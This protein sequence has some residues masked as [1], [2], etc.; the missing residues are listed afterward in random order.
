MVKPT[1][2]YLCTPIFRPLPGRQCDCSPRLSVQKADSSQGC[3]FICRAGRQAGSN[4]GG[5]RSS[6][7]VSATVLAASFTLPEGEGQGPPRTPIPPR[8]APAGEGWPHAA[9][10][11]QAAETCLR[12]VA[13]AAGRGGYPTQSRLARRSHHRRRCDGFTSTRQ[14]WRLMADPINQ[15]YPITGHTKSVDLWRRSAEYA[16]RCTQSRRP[17]SRPPRS[18]AIPLHVMWLCCLRQIKDSQ[19]L[20]CLTFRAPHAIAAPPSVA[21]YQNG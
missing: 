19:P 21:K 13:T 5:T 12:C 15:H 11:T 4:A 1:R 10:F 16:E 17:D 14:K 9:K 2:L 3:Q 20:R 6:R 8:R 7:M 18:D